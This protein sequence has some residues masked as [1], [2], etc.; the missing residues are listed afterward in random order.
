MK[1]TP[2]RR[3]RFSPKRTSKQQ[4]HYE[5]MN[6]LRPQLIARSGGRCECGRDCQ[7][8]GAHAHHVIRRSQGGP[9]TLDNL[10]WLSLSCHFWT[11]THIAEARRLGLLASPYQEMPCDH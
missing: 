10:R 4:A 8:Q 6:E 9:D 5:A 11:H 7:S 3:S 2:L 1:R